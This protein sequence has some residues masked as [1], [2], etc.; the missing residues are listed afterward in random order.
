MKPERER[1]HLFRFLVFGWNGKNF[2]FSE[3]FTL[4]EFPR[5]RRKLANIYSKGICSGKEGDGR[6][7]AGNRQPEELTAERKTERH[8]GVITVPAFFTG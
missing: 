8:A 6:L 7:S 2:G 1:K 5:I 4:Y 3:M